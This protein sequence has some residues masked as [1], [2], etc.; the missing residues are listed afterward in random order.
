M[1]GS[2]GGPRAAA[3]PGRAVPGP[4][5]GTS[6]PV[7]RV[8]VRGGPRGR[9]GRA[10]WPPAGGHR[11]VAG[12]AV[13]GRLREPHDLAPL[14]Y[15]TDLEVSAAVMAFGLRSSRVIFTLV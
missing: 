10:G 6:S 13:R 5:T 8:L 3:R 4:R 2:P 9:R 11:R 7:E 12:R 15:R 14:W 1:A